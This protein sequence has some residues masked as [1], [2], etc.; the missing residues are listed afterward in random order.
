MS[1]KTSDDKFYD[2]SSNKPLQQQ[3]QPKHVNDE[4]FQ[5]NLSMHTRIQPGQFSD[6]SV[7]YA[8]HVNKALISDMRRFV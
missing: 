7:N 6:V 4:N 1:Q 5:R 3:Q 2:I 8:E